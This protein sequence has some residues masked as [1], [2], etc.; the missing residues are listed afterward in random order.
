MSKLIPFAVFTRWKGTEVY[1][2]DGDQILEP[3]YELQLINVD[4]V[5]KVRSSG[6]RSDFYGISGDLIVS[7]KE[8][9]SEISEMVS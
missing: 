7:V 2:E 4:H 1:D 9:L 5:V 6:E 3:V 8:S